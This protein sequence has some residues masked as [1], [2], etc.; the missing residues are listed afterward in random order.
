M[1][2]LSIIV[3]VSWIKNINLSDLNRYLF[4]INWNINE[5]DN[6]LSIQYDIDDFLYFIDNDC[7]YVIEMHD[8][9]SFDKRFNDFLERNLNRY[10][11]Q[12]RKRKSCFRT[13]KLICLLIRLYQFYQFVNVIFSFL[14][15]QDIQFLQS[16]VNIS[17]DNHNLVNKLKYHDVRIRRIKIVFTNQFNSIKIR[18]S[19]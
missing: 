18:K 4:E 16:I 3:T 13:E 15:A 10:R 19:L 17:H 7:S 5:Q 8:L 14:R 9:E 1:F 2:R 12:N 6:W 11:W